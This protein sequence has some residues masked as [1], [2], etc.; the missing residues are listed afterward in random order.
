ME[1]RIQVIRLI[2]A[3]FIVCV[4]FSAL[5]SL[6]LVFSDYW[7]ISRIAFTFFHGLWYG[8]SFGLMLA[9]F[10]CLAYWFVYRYLH[11]RGYKIALVVGALFSIPGVLF[12]DISLF[13]V[14]PVIGV[15]YTVLVHLTYSGLNSNH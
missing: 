7:E 4:L 1:E 11:V 10:I 12:G 5:L 15:A 9:V 2:C 8:M 14:L 6:L 3:A 13:L